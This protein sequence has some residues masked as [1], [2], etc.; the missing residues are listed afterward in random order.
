MVQFIK[1]KKSSYINKP[2][3]VVSV[4]TGGIQAGKVQSDV[5]NSIATM[6]IKEATEQE[7][8]KGQ[9]YVQNLPT[10]KMIV[11]ETDLEGNPSVVR[12]EL[13]FEPLDSNL[14]TIAKQTA[15]PLLQKKYALALS[16]DIAKNIEEIRL[17]STSSEEFQTKI[18][19]FLPTYIEQINKLGGGNFTSQIQE[20]VGKL[21]TQHFFDMA[22]KE[23]NLNIV[24]QANETN[25][26][27]LSSIQETEASAT[28]YANMGDFAS[29]LK[30]LKA[31]QKDQ[32]SV[33]NSSVS[34]YGLIGYTKT[35]IDAM[36]IKI[37][38]SP[39]RGLLK[40]FSRGKNSLQLE[41]AES[42]LRNGSKG[43]ELSAKD[44]EFLDVIK[45]EAGKH[46]G[47]LIED[48]S[49]LSASI[50]TVQADRRTFN[51]DRDSGITKAETK[52]K[53]IEFF[54]YYESKI[55]NKKND[56]KRQNRSCSET[57]RGAKK[58]YL[59]VD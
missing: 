24:N 56:K 35:Q 54:K 23:K 43:P 36:K 42:Y 59:G 41:L 32:L 52:I 11:E 46:V 18:N 5:F 51:N 57:Y 2:V 8:Q 4:D 37:A 49:K 12:S 1:A 6:Y 3:G 13:N 58:T 25:N 39:A 47:Y 15:K 19:N 28:N 21:S 53:Y 45:N 10:R 22:L 20:G 26:A 48:A 29:F 34:E 7:I 44:Y 14:S 9:D 55:L 17:D 38:I 50:R 16:N 27:L 40:G 31:Q 33:F 30:E